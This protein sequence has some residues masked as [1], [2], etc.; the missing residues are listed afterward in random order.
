MNR[1]PARD[2]Q[3]RL[4]IRSELEQ[5]LAVVILGGMLSSTAL[6]LLVIPAL[7]QL[8]GEKA[9]HAIPLDGK[10]VVIKGTYCE[11]TKVETG[12]HRQIVVTD[13]LPA[14]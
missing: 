10:W 4:R 9:L 3:S 8:S 5:P 7:F 13:L 14:K 11:V 12:L 2:E 1:Q 6:T